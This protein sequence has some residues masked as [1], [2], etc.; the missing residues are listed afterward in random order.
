MAPPHDEPLLSREKRP[1]R[2]LLSHLHKRFELA[3]CTVGPTGLGI[4]I[5][6]WR[7]AVNVLSKS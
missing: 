2:P 4:V 5:A 6:V 1:K 3:T 7:Q